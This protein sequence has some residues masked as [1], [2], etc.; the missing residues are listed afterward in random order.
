MLYTCIING[1]M[2]DGAP[3]GQMTIPR[4][5][6]RTKRLSIKEIK[7]QLDVLTA[8]LKEYEQEANR[9][10]MT[11]CKFISDGLRMSQEV[12]QLQR[13]NATLRKEIETLRQATGI[14]WN[15]ESGV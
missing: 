7:I 15:R 13:E 2:P 14:G 10:T 5:V 12:E 1:I 6:R 8:R 9:C 11:G 3:L 4:D